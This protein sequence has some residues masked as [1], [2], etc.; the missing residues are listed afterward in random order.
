MDKIMDDKISLVN[1]QIEYLWNQASK[2]PPTNPKYNAERQRTYEGLAEQF[3]SLKEYLEQQ[4]A[5]LSA[6][7]DT[8][9]I[10]KRF[11]NLD[12][13]PEHMLKQSRVTKTDELERQILQI[14]REDFDNIAGIDEIFFQLYRRFKVDMER[15]F[16]AGKISRM[17]TRT[18]IEPYQSK[19][20]V[21]QICES[22]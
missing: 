9:E 3:K 21:Y 8:G 16:L 1:R 6:R 19:K 11:G 17:V 5:I 7:T 4:A 13:I 12:D 2:Y 20:G 22:E 15:K 10:G 18:L 14:M